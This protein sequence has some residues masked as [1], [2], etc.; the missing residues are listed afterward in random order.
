MR[1]RA[2]APF[3]PCG[4][5]W[6]PEGT[7]DEG[8]GPATSRFFAT[9]GDAVFQTA[10]PQRPLIRPLSPATFCRKGRRGRSP[11]KFVS[12][13]I[14]RRAFLAGLGGA[15]A[16]WP[17]VA[18][19]DQRVARIGFLAPAYADAVNGA[20]A[21]FRAGLSE[22]GYVEG[23]NLE[24][25]SRF[26]VGPD[27]ETELARELLDLEVDVIVSDGDGVLAAHKV[28]KTVPIVAAAAFDLVELGLAESLGHP[29]GNVTGLS[30]FVSELQVKRVALL[31]QVRPAMTSV[32]LLILQ[33]LAASPRLLR[34]LEASVKA[35]GV[36]LKPIEVADPGDCKRAL[37]SGPGASI[38]GLVVTDPPQFIQGAGPV[39]IAAAA[40][41]NGLPSAGAPSFATYGGLLGFGVDLIPMFRRAAVFVDKILKGAKPGDIPIEQATKFV[42]IVNLKAAH[43]LGLDIPPDILAAADEVI[44]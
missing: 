29:G 7:P 4:R 38:G 40:A 21:A 1:R 10:R 20:F 8:F 34:A 13:E 14:G 37:S 33:G 28:T 44:E 2:P 32:G 23:G 18:R 41:R 5:R 35:L 11:P 31:K 39:T 27:E 6:R 12:F 24:I 25:K 22:L 3:S 36:E 19:A 26:W 30:F 42:M 43:A 9:P 15:A 17:F 16:A